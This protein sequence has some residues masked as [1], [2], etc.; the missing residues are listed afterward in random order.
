ML[1]I[2][3][4]VL[5][6]G[7]LLRRLVQS[8][9]VEAEILIVVNSIGA[10]DRSVED[11]VGELENRESN[12]V[13]VRVHRT[14]GN[15]GVAGSWNFILDHFGGDC[16]ISNS[17]IE[18]APGVLG[19]AMAAIEREPD[20][21]MQHLWA[22]SCFYVTKSFGATLG[23]F[24]ENIYPAYHEDQEIHLRCGALGVRHRSVPEAKNGILHGGSETRNS[25]TEAVRTYIRKAKALS[26]DYLARR[27]GAMP[28]PGIHQ[29][30]K[31]HPFDDPSR[32][33]ADWTLDLDARRRVAA[34]CKEITGFDCPIVYHREK[35]GLA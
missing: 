15:L 25:A 4:P 3:V 27:W 10:L 34:L 14:A 6:R 31:K 5:N 19:R 30:E 1:R 17:D 33:P 16:V 35:G 2:G 18:F 9:D 29:P 20:C 23:W 11:A 13:R 7:D 32:H 12:G 22:A 26:G 28:P 21:V 8:V 24:D